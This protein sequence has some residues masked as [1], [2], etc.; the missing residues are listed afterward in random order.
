MRSLYVLCI[1]TL[2]AVVLDIVLFHSRSVGAADVPTV[3]VD[4]I[5][6]DTTRTSGSVLAFG[7]IVGFHC[8]QGVIN[9]ECFVA[10]AS[11]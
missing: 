11:N 10:S 3:R 8:I 6:W 1:V 7:H 9:A 5:I 2:A 4:R